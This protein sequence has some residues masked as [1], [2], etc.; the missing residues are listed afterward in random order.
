LARWVEGQILHVLLDNAGRHGSGTVTV[1]VRD[2]GDALAIDVIDEGPGID[3]PGD[4]LF[5]RGA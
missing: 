5:R 2:A 4:E 3:R 1:N